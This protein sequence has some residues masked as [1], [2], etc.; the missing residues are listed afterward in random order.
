MDEDDGEVNTFVR[1]CKNC[2]ALLIGSIYRHFRGN[3]FRASYLGRFSRE[4]FPTQAVIREKF[5]SQPIWEI[6][7]QLPWY[8]VCCRLA[9]GFEFV[10]QLPPRQ[11]EA[12]SNPFPTT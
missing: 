10:T 6:F 8:L 12:S 5:S 2:K 7:R 4:V 3:S 11:H 1:E 9:D